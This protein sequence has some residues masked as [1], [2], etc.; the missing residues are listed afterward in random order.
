LWQQACS[1]TIQRGQHVVEA[2]AALVGVVVRVGLDHEA[3]VG[4]Q[5]AVVLPARVADQHLGGRVQLLQEVGAQL[6]TAGAAQGLHGGHAAGVEDVAAGA[7]HQA[8]H[9]LVVGGDAV[10][11]QVA[12]RLVGFHQLRLGGLHALQQRQLAVVVE[13]H[14][15]AQVDLGGVGVGIELLVE[16]QDRVARGEFDGSEQRHLKTSCQKGVSSLAGAMGGEAAGPR[17]AALRCRFIA[18]R[19][20]EPQAREF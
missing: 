15:D 17:V 11:R 4:E 10:D 9:G 8:L 14:A 6:Q 5:R 12:A 3:G 20:H 16:A 1:T 18:R 7:E 2:H 19:G 13:V